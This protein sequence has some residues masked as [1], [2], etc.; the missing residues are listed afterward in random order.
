MI[1][2][3]TRPLPA[4]AIAGV[5]VSAGIAVALG[6]LAAASP[7]V[8]LFAV[9]LA[10]GLA[11]AHARPTIAIHILVVSFLF[12]GYLSPPDQFV[13]FE[14]AIGLL[15]LCACAMAWVSGRWRWIR[16]SG[17]APLVLLIIW[18]VPTGLLARAPGSA[19]VT[20]ARYASFAIVYLVVVQ[21]GQGEFDRIAG[22][23]RTLVVA[24]GA[25]SVVGLFVFATGG[26]Y[27]VSGPISDPNDTAFILDPAYPSRCGWADIANGEPGS[28]LADCVPS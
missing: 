13:T 27:R 5:A 4:G 8:A 11:L 6:G 28:G 21:F 25:S 16:T 20:S 7:R 22:L 1:A 26:A 17:T 24:A 19:I 10:L 23:I 12:Q 14:K 9:A 18:L 15:G 2:R 3:G